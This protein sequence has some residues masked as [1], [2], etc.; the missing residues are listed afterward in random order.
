MKKYFT[1]NLKTIITAAF[2]IIAEGFIT[3]S[4]SQVQGRVQQRNRYGQSGAKLNIVCSFSDYATITRE[5]AGDRAEVSFIANGEQDPH[6]VPP[7]PSFAVMLSSADMWIA[8]GMDL[9][10]WSATLLDKARNRKIM[11]GEPGFVSVSDGINILEKVEFGDRTEGDVHLMGNPHITTSPV[12]WKVIA[13]NIT[14]GLMKVDPANAAFYEQNRDAYIN[15]IDRALFGDRLVDLFGGETL[16]KL[17]ENNTLFTFLERPYEGGKLSD[18]L[19]GWLKKALPLRGKRIIAY[20]KNWSYLTNTFGLEVMGYIEP[21]PGIPPSAKHVQN[22]IQL[23]KEQDINLMVVASYF[24]KKTATMIEQKTGIKA[25]YLPLFV[26][27]PEGIED[28]FDLLDLW[29]DQILK[30]IQ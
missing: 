26:H 1:S 22:M 6:F 10:M 18:L 9:E 28:N 19:G 27:G 2:L 8:T 15:R 24:E 4:L 16:T 29:L 23:I 21:K 30:N 20:H 14:I 3:T 5:I 25:L 7:K 12:N 17:L 11:D 13:R